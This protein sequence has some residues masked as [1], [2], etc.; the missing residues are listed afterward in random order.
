MD[1][2]RVEYSRS[3][4]KCGQNCSLVL[5]GPYKTSHVPAAQIILKSDFIIDGY[6]FRLVIYDQHVGAPNAAPGVM[7]INWCVSARLPLGMK[8]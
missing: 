4:A 2:E 5:H 6:Y 7:T 8:M 1:F 3:E